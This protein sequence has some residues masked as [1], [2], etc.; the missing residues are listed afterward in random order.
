MCGAEVEG[1]EL[2]AVH[3]VYLHP[4]EQV[5]DDVERWCVPCRV[6]Y[7]HETA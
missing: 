4:E 3:R 2:A 6:T 5:L 1:D 7:P